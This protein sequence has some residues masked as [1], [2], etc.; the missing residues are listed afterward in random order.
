MKKI[1]IVLANRPRMARQVVRDMIERQDD[2]EVVREAQGRFELL[3]AVKETHADAVILS[4][5]DSEVPG[6]CSHLLAE[7]PGL[8]ILAL[9]IEGGR[10]FVEQLCPS[11]RE[12]VNP[13]SENV[14]AALREAMGQ[15]C[16]WIEQRERRQPE[17]PGGITESAR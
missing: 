12:I 10:A 1:R 6:L 11:R 2:M 8:T 3:I 17:S 14:L 13:S 5:G 9:G 7:Y 15:P 4:M 16:G